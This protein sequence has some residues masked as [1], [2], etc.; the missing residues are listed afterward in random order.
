MYPNDFGAPMDE[1]AETMLGTAVGVLFVVYIIVVLIALAIAAVSYIL[2]SLSLYTIATRRG[3]KNPWLAWV[4]VVSC[5][6]VGCISDQYRYVTKG[7]VKNKRK[8]LL[9]LSIITAVLE[10]A[11]MF[12]NV[13]TMINFGGAVEDNMMAVA[14]TMAAVMV[15]ISLVL[16][17][18]TI[19]FAVINYMAL[20]DLYRSC[21]PNNATLYLVLSIVISWLMPVFLMIVRKKDGGMPPR[22]ADVEQIPAQPQEAPAPAEEPLQQPAEEAEPWNHPETEE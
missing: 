5:W 2:R 11:S 10:M 12:N 15:I 14:G 3:I 17:G 13:L 20:Y 16:A 9:T 21:E 8:A 6:T 7:E 18:V 4:P 1:M 19:A 22:K